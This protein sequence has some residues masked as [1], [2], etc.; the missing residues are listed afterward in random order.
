MQPCIGGTIDDYMGAFVGVSSPVSVDTTFSVDVKYV[1]PGNSCVGP[2][3]T[4]GFSITIL[5]GQTSSNFDAC[6]YGAY[7]PAGAVI[8][9]ACIG[10][11]DNPEVDFTAN[12]C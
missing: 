5:A 4:Q 12:S 7:F 6:S 10:S 11:C 1:Q 3:S 8:C 2:N 9:S